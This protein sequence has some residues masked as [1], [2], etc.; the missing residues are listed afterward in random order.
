MTR[1]STTTILDRDLQRLR[2]LIKEGKLL[3]PVPDVNDDRISFADMAQGLA[4]CCD[5]SVTCGAVPPAGQQLPQSKV[6]I[7]LRDLE[8]ENGRV[9]KTDGAIHAISNGVSHPGRFPQ[10]IVFVLCD[11]M[12]NAVLNTHLG[13][14]HTGTRSFLQ[15]HNNRSKMQAVFPAT[16]PAA[17]T[18]LVTGV[19]PGQHGAPGWDLRDQK[20]CEFPVGLPAR[21]AQG[22]A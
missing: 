17:L 20:K 2:E 4:I 3:H 22:V 9:D 10:H 18:T 5:R 14:P 1:P 19:W 8:H 21:H 16:T 6:D 13:P 11:G 7:F 15:T 12:G